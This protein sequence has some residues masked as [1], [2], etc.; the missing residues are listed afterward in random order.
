MKVAA[1]PV[2][3]LTVIL[4]VPD[5]PVALPVRAPTKVVAVATP[6]L[7]PEALNVFDDPVISNSVAVAT[8]VS[9]K[10]LPKIVPV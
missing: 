1:E 10:L 5:K 3:L 6:T 8:P 4:G 7:R 9:D 2:T